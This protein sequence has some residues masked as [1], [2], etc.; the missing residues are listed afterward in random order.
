METRHHHHAFP[1]FKNRHLENRN[2]MLKK[3]NQAQTLAHIYKCLAIVRTIF[4]IFVTDSTSALKMNEQ[5]KGTV[6]IKANKLGCL[7]GNA[8]SLLDY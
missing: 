8:E 3:T 6:S 1:N 5:E 4:P 2:R 7:V